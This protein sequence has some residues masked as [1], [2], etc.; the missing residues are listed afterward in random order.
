MKPAL[1][2]AAAAALHWS[3]IVWEPWLGKPH[4][5]LMIQARLDGRGSGLLQLDTGAWK[6]ALY[7]PGGADITVS[8]SIAGREFEREPFGFRSDEAKPG[9][10]G[11]VGLSFFAQRVLILDFVKGRLAILGEGSGFPAI[12]SG[13]SNLCRC[14]WSAACC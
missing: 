6:S 7:R 4:A 12:S 5:E 11:T 10:L 14:E 3:N 1:L 2:L 13:D 8:G 9:R